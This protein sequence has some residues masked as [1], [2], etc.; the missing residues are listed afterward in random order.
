MPGS[1]LYRALLKLFPR[2]FRG[3][4]GDQMEA[5]FHDQR[6]DARKAGQRSAGVWTRMLVDM[7]QRAPRE[8]VDILRRDAGYALRLFRR[9]PGMT[10]SAL[11]TLA[12]GI[13]LNAAVFSV[14]HG[15]LWRS[16]PLP[17]SS[18]LV[19]LAEVG[20][21]PERMEA[22]VSQASFDSWARE[23]RTLDAIGSIRITSAT[24]MQG[25]GAERLM[26]GEVSRGFFATLS[27]RPL[28]GRLF[29]D[30]DFASDAAV[31]VA[32]IG[33]D[34]WKR[35]FGGRSEVIGERVNLGQAGMVE[36]VGVLEPAFVFPLFRNAAIMLPDVPTGSPYRSPMMA[37]GRLAPGAT[38]RGL[39]TELDL[40][41][42]RLAAAAADPGRAPGVRVTSLRDQVT[43]GAKTQLWFLFGTASCVLLIV[44]ANVSNLLL[45]HTAGRRR[46]L[47]TRAALGASRAHLVRQGLTEG[48]VLALV[49]GI[50]GFL[51]AGWT[52]PALIALAPRTIPRLGEISVGWPVLAFATVTSVC[53][54]LTCGLAA[55]LTAGR[56]APGLTLRSHRAAGNHERSRFRQGLIVAQVAVA[57]VLAVAAGLLVQ[58]MRA[59]TALPLGY[60]PSN[61]ISI[62]FS[63]GELGIEGTAAKASLERNLIEAIRSVEGVTAAGVGSPPLNRSYFSISIAMPSKPS[64]PADLHAEFAGPGYL[65]ALGARLVAGRFF[66][67]RDGPQG[68]PAALVNESAA[69][70]LWPAGAIGQTFLHNQ[71]PIVIIGMVNDVRRTGLEAQPQSTI[72][73]SSAQNANYWTNNMLVRT[74]GDPRELL[75]AIRTAVRQVD[76]RL[77]FTSVETLAQR[78]DLATAPRRFNLWLVSLFSII[79]LGLAVVGIYGVVMESV[80]QRVPEIGVRMALGASAAGVTRMVLGQG[81][82]MIGIGIALGMAA[83]LALNGVMAAFVFGVQT[84]DPVSLGIACAVLAAAGLL[85]CAIPARRAARVDPVVALRAE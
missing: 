58:T 49:G 78:L 21:P 35:Q 22:W 25:G 3:D 77:P 15:V 61:V 52:V 74:S 70:R 62:G 24:L 45:T 68:Q 32:V 53:V 56:S 63:P 6:E 7:L 54:G 33:H 76:A 17:H 8:H 11:L 42:S 26:G 85:A 50:A 66:E 67:D 46:E 81:T 23:A 75:P 84:T 14:V 71:K 30:G 29:N 12:I 72:Y 38:V 31:R 55:S 64:E 27:A 9:R 57:L 80:A 59:V 10:A 47:V 60:D 16:L 48:M 82:W 36:V 20:P 37:I 73:L 41:A 40:V 51:L 19:Y 69:K 18:R 44:C 83:V 13:G 43:S 65:E 1:R 4:F 28:L 34:L 39:Q 5:D 2:E 79:A